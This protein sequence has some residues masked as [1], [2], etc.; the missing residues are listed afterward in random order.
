MNSSN[1]N[2][3]NYNLNINNN[4]LSIIKQPDVLINNTNQRDSKYI[5]TKSNVEN[6]NDIYNDNTHLPN[7][8]HYYPKPY[9]IASNNT[10]KNDKISNKLEE[11]YNNMDIEE[12]ELG[13]MSPIV[14]Y[15]G[16]QQF[17]LDYLNQCRGKRHYYNKLNS[18]VLS[19]IKNPVTLS[20]NRFIDESNREYLINNQNYIPYRE[21]K[22][23]TSN[24]NNKI[25]HNDQYDYTSIRDKN[26]NENIDRYLQYILDDEDKNNK[27]KRKN[28]TYT[29]NKADISDINYK[30]YGNSDFSS[31]Y[32]QSYKPYKELA[33]K[34]YNT[35]LPN[36]NYY[37]D[38]SK[39]NNKYTNN[40][41]PYK[42][43][44]NQ[45]PLNSPYHKITSQS[46][47]A[48]DVPRT[49][50]I[51]EKEYLKNIS[52]I[53]ETYDN[54]MYSSALK[55]KSNNYNEFDYKYN[56]NSKDKQREIEKLRKVFY[57]HEMNK[58]NKSLK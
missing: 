4:K 9:K 56:A 31:T 6:A 28:F 53:R 19:D 57:E 51:K 27:I 39:N 38:N 36:N 46:M 45:S 54:I 20:P 29:Y 30:N 25:D 33:I 37:N 16:E 58:R 21:V 14:K 17:Y 23:S 32:N 18:N 35:Y 24:S 7:N 11:L 5:N 10:D 13:R 55:N 42:L 43:Y 34:E 49:G 48:V 41:I 2:R 47:N 22:G 15:T 26:K 1:A 8:Y 40:Q 12:K 50:N 44:N 3:D 52:G